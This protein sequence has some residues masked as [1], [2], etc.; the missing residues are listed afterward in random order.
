M[1]IREMKKILIAALFAAFLTVAPHAGFAQEADDSDQEKDTATAEQQE[2]EDSAEQPVEDVGDIVVSATKLETPSREVGSSLSVI[3][4]EQLQRRQTRTVADALKTVQGLHVVETAGPGQT[5]SVFMR[6]AKSEHTL[7][8][9]DGV[10]MNDPIS[11]GRAFDFAD[12]T[13]ENIE[14][15]EVLRGPQ[16]TLYGSDAMGGVINI[17][18]KKGKGKPG[19]FVSAEAG[20]F[21]TFRERAHAS[22]SYKWLDYSLGFSRLDTD[23]ISAAEEGAGNDEEDGYGNTSISAKL[24]I[25]PT[26]MFN[27][28]TMVRYTDALV[29]LDNFGGVGGDDPN[30]E[31]D[32]EELFLRTEAELS[33]FDELWE[34]ELGFS[35]TDYDRD[36]RNDTDLAHP[37]SLSQ[38]SFDGRIVQFDWQHNLYLHETNTLTLG[39]ETEEER[40][41]SDFFSQSSFGTTSTSFAEETART[42]SAYIQDQIRLWDSFF[43]TVGARLD[44]HEDFGSETTYRVAPAYVFKETGTKIKGSYGTGF[45]APTLYQLFSQYGNSNLDAEESTGWDAGVEQSLFEEKLT[46]GATYFSNEFDDLIDFNTGTSS[47]RNVAEAETDGI[48]LSADYR[49]I[50]KLTT[51]LTY[52]YTDTEDE[53]T[54][55]ELL[56]RADNK[57][58]FD[59]GYDVL[60]NWQVNL[61]IVY[62]GER[63]D[64]DFSTWPASRVELDDYALVNLASSYQVTEHTEL[65][66][67][68]ENLF[69]EDY[70][71]VKGFGTPGIGAYGGV[72]VS[73]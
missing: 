34:Q 59:I 51:G 25:T 19:G 67:R 33:L 1:E 6:G 15:I 68:I 31:S 26:E 12:L 46:L 57:V 21:S 29:E 39:L 4:R 55:E 56:R 63:D 36:V 3:T 2:S 41:E 13:T 28:D 35:L 17:I 54:G 8:L 44:D 65:F 42:N 45:K 37:N 47:F 70:Q 52:T 40:G 18:T 27:V 23:G 49:P 38:S 9:I 58:T 62:V 50:E 60:E 30:H 10:E 72:K 5:T 64:M 24:G 14:R 66:G 20:S 61:Q 16:S 71:E 32:Q 11:P 22:G 7:V 69:D 43:T 53:S 48:E 73:F